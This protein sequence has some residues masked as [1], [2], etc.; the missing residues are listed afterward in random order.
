[1]PDG[2]ALVIR[3]DGHRIHEGASCYDQQQ[4]MLV[5]NV[6]AVEGIEDRGGRPIPSIVRLFAFDEPLSGKRDALYL[7][8]ING[9]FEFLRRLCDGKAVV[10]VDGSTPL[11]NHG[12]DEMIKTGAQLVNNLAGND[13][14]ARGQRAILKAYPLVGTSF[15]LRLS[16]N[17]V[18][19]GIGK[20]EGVNLGL[21]VLDVL[22]GPFNLCPAPLPEI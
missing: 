10:F 7:S 3:V 11:A 1:M 8:A 17:S 20:K 13:R 5:F 12:H 4:A 18:G 6:I 14:D 21:E 22:F 16:D 2:V 19:L 15:V 9:R